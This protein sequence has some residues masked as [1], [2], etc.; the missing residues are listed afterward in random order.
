M[1]V[2][3]G[4]ASSSLVRTATREAEKA[5]GRAEPFFFQSQVVKKSALIGHFKRSLGQI[6]FITAILFS[7]LVLHAKIV[8]QHGQGCF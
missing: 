2:T 4:V 3:H 8:L 6:H 1:P 5:C 7:G